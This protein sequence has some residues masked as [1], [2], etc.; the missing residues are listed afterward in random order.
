MPTKK[1]ILARSLSSILILTS[2]VAHGQQLEDLDKKGRTVQTSGNQAQWWKKSV[3]YQIYPRSFKDS[4]NDGI[5]DLQGIISKLDYLQ[6]LGVDTVYMNPHYDSPNVDYGYDVRDYRKVLAE[7]G[8]MKDFDSLVAQLHKRHM[9]LIIDGVF[10]HTSSEN[11]WFQGSRSSLSNP[12]RDYYLWRSNKKPSQQGEGGSIFGG[13]PWEY[14]KTTNQYYLHLFSKYQPD[15]NW[16]NPKVRDEVYSILKFWLDKGVS[17]IRFDSI[18]TISKGAD[19]LN[20][21]ST[22]GNIQSFSKGP[23]LHQY[24]HEMNEKVLAKYPGT[25]SIGEM[26]GIEQSQ[27]PLFVDQRR[28]ELDAALNV[29]LLWDDGGLSGGPPGGQPGGKPPGGQGGQP[30]GGQ[31]GAGM[32][33]AGGGGPNH[34]GHTFHL[35][36]F[37]QKVASLDKAVGQYGWNTF[38]LTNHDNSRA[39]SHFGAPNGPYRLASAKALATVVLTQR[40]TPIIYQGDEIG[41]T[42]YVDRSAASTSTPATGTI[43]QKTQVTQVGQA[44]VE[45]RSPF[46]WNS[47]PY[48]GFSAVK[49]WLAVNSDYKTVNADENV[50]DPDSI[51]HYYRKLIDIR[52]A[53]PALVYGTYEDVDPSNDKVYAYQRTYRGQKYLVV[54]NFTDQELDYALPDGRKIQFAVIQA[55]TAAPLAK[56]VGTLHLKAWQSGI[57]RLKK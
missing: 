23:H 44:R 40:A 1:S 6:D 3:I 22:D 28:Q 41:M 27:L 15:L 9:R 49:P 7:F 36:Q 21:S 55:Q 26:V 4:N 14:D 31:P 5:G 53:I 20:S 42:N 19:F 8:T 38:F 17:G 32:G 25:V 56:G 29:D 16:D 35:A 10:N 11:V 47:S 46:Q 54:A 2:L 34:Q 45:S 37:R 57:Y 52:H 43:Q 30:P 24:I 51:Y 39:L 12:Y 48:S 50:R 13:S 18:A 33:G